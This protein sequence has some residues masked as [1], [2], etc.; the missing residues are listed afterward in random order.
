MRDHIAN[1]LSLTNLSL[2]FVSMFFSIQGNF[3]YSAYMIIA[4][5]AIDSI[6]GTVARLLKTVTIFGKELDGVSDVISFVAAPAIFSYMVFSETFAYPINYIFIFL[7]LVLV[8]SGVIRVA[9]LN[10]GQITGWH[11]MKITFN[12]LI[13]VLYILGFFS[14][15]IISGW[16]LLSSVFMLSKFS[17]RDFAR[18]KNKKDK[19]LEIKSTHHQEEHK[20]ENKEEDKEEGL[21]P[22]AMFGD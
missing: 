22:L 8:V 12:T 11:G 18:R 21:V 13:P 7:L 1:I 17:L 5:A 10:S 6:D 16:I 19:I 3:I 15:Y 14:V 2:G 20:E 9:R 4:A